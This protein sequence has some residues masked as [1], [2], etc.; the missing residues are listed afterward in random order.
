MASR[1]GYGLDN[2]KGMC[3][4]GPTQEGGGGEGVWS[5]RGSYFVP[6]KISTAEFVYPKKIPT[7]FCI[8]QKIQHQQ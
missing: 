6:Q 3:P 2:S 1:P 7:L 4:R 5:G 8:P